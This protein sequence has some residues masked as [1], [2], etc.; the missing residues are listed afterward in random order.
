M[1]IRDRLSH[2]VPHWIE[3]N[4]AHAEQF[5]EWVER[6]QKAGLESVAEEVQAAQR[7][8]QQAN[9]ALQRARAALQQDR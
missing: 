8:L 4:D 6:A 9:E 1:E 7:A 2:L 5:A 3:H